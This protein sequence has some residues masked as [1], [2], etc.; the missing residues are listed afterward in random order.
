MEE[1]IH[2]LDDTTALQLLSTI[3]QPYTVLKELVRK[4]AGFLPGS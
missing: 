3:A 1:K 4:V 2:H